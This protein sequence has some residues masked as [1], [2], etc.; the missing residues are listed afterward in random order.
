[1]LERKTVDYVE[2]DQKVYYQAVRLEVGGQDVWIVQTHLDWTTFK[3]GFEHCREMQMQ[4]LIDDFRDAPRVII[5]GDFNVG[6]SGA[7]GIR[8]ENTIPTP[9]E[10]DVFARAGYT[11]ANSDGTPTY[12]S[13]RPTQPLDNIVVKGL[14]ISNVRFHPA[15]D[16]SD[17]NAVSCTLTLRR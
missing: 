13:D 12:P 6:D 2:R 16:L 3:K 5:S 17:H 1:M 15:G 4:K 9:E 10:Y 14:E 7:N 8:R 11:L